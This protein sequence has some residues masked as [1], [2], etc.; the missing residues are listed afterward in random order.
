M[1]GLL[2]DANIEGH[3]RALARILDGDAWR[4][5]WAALNLSLRFFRDVGLAPN[6]SDAAV[7]SFCQ[8]EELILLTANRNESGPDSLEAVLRARNSP[9]SL[10]V[11]TLADPRHFEL[12]RE[13][14]ERVAE[15]LLEYLMDIEQ[16]RGAGRL[17]LP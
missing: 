9:T 7:W 6:A 4:E 3:V 2:S 12:S 5:V 1:K 11:F 13:Y 17:F 15:R 16:F 14:A 8:Q 10:P